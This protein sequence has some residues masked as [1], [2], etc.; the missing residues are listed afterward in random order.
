M[1]HLRQKRKA[2]NAPN[3]RV[4][5][6]DVL[7]TQHLCGAVL[8]HTD[9]VFAFREFPVQLKRKEAKRGKVGPRRGKV[10]PKGKAGPRGKQARE[11]SRP[12]R[13]GRPVL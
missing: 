4:T 9:A 8:S 1:R 11:G 3:C 10:G 2:E 12:E 7:I 6:E 13:E 5:F